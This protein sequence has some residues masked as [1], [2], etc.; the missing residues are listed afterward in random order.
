MNM[1]RILA[2]VLA[3]ILT[4][5]G[6]TSAIY[7]QPQ[8]ENAVGLSFGTHA[9]YFAPGNTFSN[10]EVPG[11]RHWTTELTN[12]L[13]DPGSVIPNATVGLS[14][15]LEFDF[16]QEENLEIEG[17]PLYQWSYTEITPGGHAKAEAS[18]KG[19]DHA[20]LYFKPGFDVSRTFEPTRFDG[21]DTRPLV[22]VVTPQDE[23]LPEFGI[24]IR[25]PQDNPELAF[26]E[27]WDGPPSEYH[28]SPDGQMLSIRELDP[29]SSETFVYNIAIT[30]NPDPYPVEILPSVS[31]QTRIGPGS[32]YDP[33]EPNSSY[34]KDITDMC[35]TCTWTWN[36]WDTNPE[37]PEDPVPVEYPISIHEGVSGVIRF[38]GYFVELSNNEVGVDFGTMWSLHVPGNEF[39]DDTVIGREWWSSNVYN[40]PDW[41]G[42]LIDELLVDANS[43]V[44]FNRFDPY[45]DVIEP[46]DFGWYFGD[47]PQDGG[48]YVSVD[49]QQ[50]N[51]PV[52]YT[53]GFDVSREVSP[54]AF[55][56]PGPHTQ[57]V[58]I[59]IIPRQPDYDRT[60]LWVDIHAE[61]TYL[62]NPVIQMPDPEQGIEMNLT[63][64]GHHLSINPQSLPPID[65]Q[66]DIEVTID[67]ELQ[68]G[69]PG[70]QFAPGVSVLTGEEILGHNGF[71]TG[72]QV[73]YSPDGMGTWTLR[74]QGDYIWNW[75]AGR[76]R[77]VDLAMISEE[78]EANDVFMSFH[79]MYSYISPDDEFVNNGVLG[80]RQWGTVLSNQLND[81]QSVIE[82]ATVSLETGIDFGNINTDN[83]DPMYNGPPLYRW[84]YSGIEPGMNAPT[85]VSHEPNDPSPVPFE[86]G[87]N[88][89][90]TVDV[91]RFDE[92]GWQTLVIKV[93]SQDVLNPW[94]AI[95]VGIPENISISASIDSCYGATD[96]HISPDGQTLGIWQAMPNPAVEYTY[97]V[98]IWV[99][100]GEGHPV[101]IRPFVEVQRELS[102]TIEFF[103]TCDTYSNGEAIV[104]PGKW[105]WD[106]SG[107]YPVAVGEQVSC[108]IR[109]EPQFEELINDVTVLFQ[110]FLTYIPSGNEFI[111]NGDVPGDISYATQ[112]INAPDNTG[113]PVSNAMIELVPNEAFDYTKPPVPGPPYQWPLGSIINGDIRQVS[114][115]N[116]EDS[117]PFDPGFNASCSADQTVFSQP[118]IQTLTITVT[119]QEEYVDM[120]IIDIFAGGDD[121]VI[122]KILSVD[123]ADDVIIAQ[124]GHRSMI[125]KLTP[126]LE[127]YTVTATIKVIPNMPQIKYRPTVRI[128]D[129]GLDPSSFG[130]GYQDSIIYYMP[131]VGTWTWSADGLYQWTWLEGNARAVLFPRDSAAL[132][133]EFSISQ[134]S[135]D[136]D[137]TQPDGDRI[138]IS[139]AFITLGE[140]AAYD[141]STDDVIISVD[142][143]EIIIPAGGFTQQGN[144]EK[145]TYSSLSGDE[146]PEVTMKIDLESGEWSLKISD[147]DASVIDNS[148]GVEITLAIGELCAVEVINMHVGGLTFIADQ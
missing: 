65:T 71:A 116:S 123:G 42:E 16:I 27:S 10:Q 13:S 58:E 130:V 97:T 61:E 67:V 102:N 15:G 121:N 148:D 129:P 86:P 31:V 53:P 94:F 45:P 60:N 19:S 79:T 104:E 38:E 18:F 113:E 120:L 107:E 103:G 134:M 9:I 96:Y 114:V 64:D 133:T 132:I 26:I 2:I 99:E 4:V 95:N 14:S 75:H 140:V 126:A 100:P 144:K 47:I 81:P 8:P 70:A 22:I 142:G 23:G 83:L 90:R 84:S 46:P 76:V 91:T 139:E 118:D 43:Q 136:F 37:D 7:A 35:D 128:Y 49:K 80:Q 20:P 143:V 12:G 146:P 147:I 40:M 108:S 105:T 74:A 117:M 145:Y 41:T 124:G 52:D 33:V 122:P 78:I 88:A 110:K 57:T 44:A 63:E 62:V 82:W 135:V 3:V 115:L 109:W 111:N 141:L 17:P 1:K 69:V 59:T 25:I 72:N 56:G 92:P 50:P 36:F 119:P 138:A 32:N 101:E 6:L 68:P 48:I 28:L 55:Y 5:V 137:A 127:E 39:T 93:K 54:A 66:W 85:F 87:F 106:M 98:L 73:S 30:V 131:E 89:S 51:I 29:Q 125:V 77:I 11:Q 21:S 34:V 24:E 112:I